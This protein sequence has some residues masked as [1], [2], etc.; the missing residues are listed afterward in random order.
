MRAFCGGSWTE[1][2]R[3]K[4]KLVNNLFRK[5]SRANRHPKTNK[6]RKMSKP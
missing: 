4:E 2:G 5:T 1:Q 3:D 6:K